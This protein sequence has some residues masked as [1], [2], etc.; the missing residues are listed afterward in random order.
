MFGI[1]VGANPGFLMRCVHRL[2]SAN[3]GFLMSCVRRLGSAIPFD[4]NSFVSDAAPPA[5]DGGKG[6]LSTPL[7]RR[8]TSRE[9]GGVAA[10]PS[11]RRD[12]QDR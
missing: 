11:P 7:S 6:D 8:N 4:E 9:G 1:H 3:P 10:M 2:G 5:W 12:A